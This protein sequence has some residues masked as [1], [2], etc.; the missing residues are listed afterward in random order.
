MTPS[1]IAACLWGVVAAILGMLPREFHWRLAYGLVVV[2]IPILG[3]VTYQNG[4]VWGLIAL[5][6]GASVLRWPLIYFG[7]WIAQPIRRLRQRE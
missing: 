7:R 2:G 5:A 1:L 6:G 3:W 4:P